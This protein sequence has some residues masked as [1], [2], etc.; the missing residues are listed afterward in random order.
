[1]IKEKGIDQFLTQ[2]KK[3]IELLEE[4]LKNFNEGRSKSFFCLA[5]ALLSIEDIE[6]ALKETL[7]RIED[8]KITQK[9]LKTKSKILKGNLSKVAEQN[10]IEL[11]LKRK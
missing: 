8:E 11:K 10:S 6:K 3:R 7:K 9:D 2:Q 4:M 1:M 5:T